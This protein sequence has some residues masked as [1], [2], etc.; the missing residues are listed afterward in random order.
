[1]GTP[2]IMK[3]S[4]EDT[5]LSSHNH[6]SLKSCMRKWLEIDLRSGYYALDGQVMDVIMRM[7]V[8]RL[9]KPYKI[10]DLIAILFAIVLIWPGPSRRREMDITSQMKSKNILNPIS[11]ENENTPV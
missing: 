7:R 2:L 4:Y 8:N 11:N 3:T 9:S 5:S 6:N 1:M 10:V